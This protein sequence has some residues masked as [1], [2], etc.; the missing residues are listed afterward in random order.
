MQ[1]ILLE[2]GHICKLLLMIVFIILGVL[3]VFTQH[4]KNMFKRFIIRDFSFY[5]RKNKVS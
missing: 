2:F 5:I 1:A 4:E 3:A